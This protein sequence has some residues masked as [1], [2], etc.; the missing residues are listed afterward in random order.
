MGSAGVAASCVESV[1]ND[2]VVDE[3]RKFYTE[4]LPSIVGTPPL[5]CDRSGAAPVRHILIH[6]DCS[7]F[8]RINC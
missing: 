4:C 8:L 7:V 1:V 2:L 5:Q 6:P 3:R